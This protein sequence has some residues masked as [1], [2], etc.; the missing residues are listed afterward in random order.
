MKWT[1]AAVATTKTNQEANH[2]G[3]AGGAKRAL[4]VER[5][6][7]NAEDAALTVTLS[8]MEVR[9]FLVKL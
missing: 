9:T 6:P 5:V 3:T 1:T 8:P 4:A 2:D 7:F